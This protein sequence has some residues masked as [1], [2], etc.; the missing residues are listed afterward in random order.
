MP[1]P[2]EIQPI[3]PKRPPAELEDRVAELAKEI[4]RRQK[5]WLSDVE[6]K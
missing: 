2:N 4:E 5:G 1:D 6:T 3:E